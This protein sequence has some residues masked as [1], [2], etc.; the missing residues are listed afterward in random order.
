MDIL[1]YDTKLLKIAKDK[2]CKII[3]GFEMFVYQAKEQL[4]I[5]FNIS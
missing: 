3:H 1:I 2:G 4:K 5:F